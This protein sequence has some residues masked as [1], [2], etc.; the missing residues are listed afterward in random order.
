ML[1]VRVAQVKKAARY[2]LHNKMLY[3]P[4]CTQAIL[5]EL[6]N[7]MSLAVSAD[8]YCKYLLQ[9]KTIGCPV[10]FLPNTL[11]LELFPLVYIL[12]LHVVIRQIIS[13]K[14]IPHLTLS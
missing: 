13:V 4:G 2:S 1:L 5:R 3:D 12:I 7:G 14:K 11:W 10:S 9:G 6:C 8:R